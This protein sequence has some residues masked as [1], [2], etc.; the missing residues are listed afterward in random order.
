MTYR[1]YQ[2]VR[3]DAAASTTTIW[4]RQKGKKRSAV[5]N[6]RLD[7]WMLNMRRQNRTSNKTSRLWGEHRESSLH[8]VP[9]KV[10]TKELVADSEQ[11]LHPLHHEQVSSGEGRFMASRQ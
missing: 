6:D 9:Y 11:G 1:R 4:R 10:E 7:Q 3:P 8:T 5:I 2:E